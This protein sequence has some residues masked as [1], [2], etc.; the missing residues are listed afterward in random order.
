MHVVL[1]APEIKTNL[2]EGEMA[3]PIGFM[4]V[5]RTLIVFEEGMEMGHRLDPQTAIRADVIQVD[6]R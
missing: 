3:A 1:R 4:M 2:A 5:F 6:P